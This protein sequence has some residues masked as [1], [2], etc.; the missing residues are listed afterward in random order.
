[1]TKHIYDEFSDAEKDRLQSL[2]Q[3]SQ[4]VNRLHANVGILQRNWQ[5]SS[6]SYTKEDGT[7]VKGQS[8]QNFSQDDFPTFDQLRQAIEH[9]HQCVATVENVASR[10]TEDQRRTVRATGNL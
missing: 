5:R 1:M 10:M 8:Q 2:A 9:Y 3:A 6:F 4:L 7:I